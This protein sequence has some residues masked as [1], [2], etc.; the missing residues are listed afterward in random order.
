MAN[1]D[2]IMDMLQSVHNGSSY[3]A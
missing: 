1:T 3:D 2:K